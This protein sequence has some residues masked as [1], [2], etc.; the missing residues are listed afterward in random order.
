MPAYVPR[1]RRSAH[2]RARPPRIRPNVYQLAHTSHPPIHA[3]RT[4]IDDDEKLLKALA[5]SRKRMD[6]REKRL[7][8]AREKRLAEHQAGNS[9]KRQKTK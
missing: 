7:Q 2:P 4:P 5:G 3:T 9:S 8:A 6:E 1:R